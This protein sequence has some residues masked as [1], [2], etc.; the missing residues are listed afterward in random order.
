VSGRA[1]Y[2]LWRIAKNALLG[3]PGASRLNERRGG[4]RTGPMYDPEYVFGILSIHLRAMAS[5]GMSTR[6]FRAL[7]LGPG[8]SLAQAFLLAVLGA[9]RVL[10]VDVKRYATPESG[11]GVYRACLRR[12]DERLEQDDALKPFRTEGSGE[13][14]RELLPEGAAFPCLGRRLDYRITRGRALPAET[15]SMDLA[16]SCSV[17]EHVEEP[18]AVYTDLARVLRAGGL[19][20]AVIDVSDHHRPGTLDF[21]RYGDRLWHRMQSRSAAATNRLRA[22]DH[23]RLIEDAGFEILS[24]RRRLAEAPPDPSEL[25]PRFRSYSPEELRTLSI[26]LAARRRA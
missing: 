3:L 9:E 16:Y 23:L 11:R 7:E 8:N 25:S 20:S 17:L 19:M 21:L 13:R 15:G 10:A 4:R 2:V 14:A 12:L 24:T 6:G 5:A 26:V 22:C 18:R 1:A